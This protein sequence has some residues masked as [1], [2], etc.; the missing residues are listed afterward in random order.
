MPGTV[1]LPIFKPWISIAKAINMAADW[2]L[3]IIYVTYKVW[4]IFMVFHGSREPRGPFSLVRLFPLVPV[5]TVINNKY[6]IR[7]GQHVTLADANFISSRC[8]V[9]FLTML[10]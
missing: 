3:Y 5:R 4:L 8:H 7:D 2:E 9:L 1:S 10:A 6:Y